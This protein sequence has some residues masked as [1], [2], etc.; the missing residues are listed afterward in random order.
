MKV[1]RR[2]AD[3]SFGAAFPATLRLFFA[4]RVHASCPDRAAGFISMATFRLTDPLLPA[5]A[6]EF[7][8][9]IGRVA[10]TVTAFTLGYGLLQLV[11]GPLGDRI[12]KLRVMSGALPLT[13]LLTPH[14][15]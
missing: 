12:G 5:I 3:F 2:P 8:V 14:A 1:T 13:S 15:R 6:D 4:A 10:M 9:S 11:Y 7:H